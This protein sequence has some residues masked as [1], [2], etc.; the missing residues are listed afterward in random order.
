MLIL[1]G[2]LSTREL[3]TNEGHIMGE[4][5]ATKSFGGKELSGTGLALSPHLQGH[6]LSSTESMDWRAEKHGVA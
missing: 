5:V 4:S 3:M 6:M 1:D 2:D